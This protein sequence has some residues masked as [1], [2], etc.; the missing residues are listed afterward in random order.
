MFLITT[1]NEDTWKKDERVLFLGEWCKMYSRKSAWSSLDFEVL[2]YH[3]DDREKYYQDYKK[4]G[5]IYEKYLKQ[6]ALLLND[7]HDC[8]HSLRYWRIVIGFWLIYFINILFD[9]YSSIKTARKYQTI[10]STFVMKNDWTKWVRA[11]I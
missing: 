6:T 3:W 10:N 1:A 11:I 9:R 8:D 5:I 4:L 7:Y 2:P